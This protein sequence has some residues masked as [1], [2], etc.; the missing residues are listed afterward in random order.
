MVSVVMADDGIAFDGVMAETAPLGGAETAFV[1]GAHDAAM[2]AACFA[3]ADGWRAKNAAPRR[4]RIIRNSIYIDWSSP[5]RPGPAGVSLR[6]AR[7]G[8]GQ[9]R[10]AGGTWKILDYCD[11]SS[12][13]LRQWA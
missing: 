7:G 3:D 2:R 4:M 13:D 12:E 11:T 8:L 9:V 6:C 1:A 10:T 5:P